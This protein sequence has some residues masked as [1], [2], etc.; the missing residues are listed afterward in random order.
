MGKTSVL[1]S[2]LSSGESAEK[3]GRYKNTEKVKCVEKSK[4][5]G[6]EKEKMDNKFRRETFD[7]TRETGGRTR[8]NIVVLGMFLAAIMLTAFFVMAAPTAVATPILDGYN[9]SDWDAVDLLATDAQDVAGN[10]SSGYDISEMWAHYDATNDTM[11]FRLDVY[12][13]PGDTDGDLNDTTSGG[14]CSDEAGIGPHETYEIWID[15]ENNG[16]WDYHITYENNAVECGENAS[17][18]ADA[19]A[20]H[21]NSSCS[22]NDHYCIVEFKILN[23]SVYGLDCYDH[24]IPYSIRGFAGTTL[25]YR[26]E[27]YTQV[28][29]VMPEA[30]FTATTECF[31][32]DTQFNDTSTPGSA[33]I[34]NWSWDFDEDGSPDS[35]D[36]NTTWH[37]PAPGTYNVTLTVTDENGCTDNITKSVTVYANPI[38]NFTVDNVCFCTN[39]TFTDTSTDPDGYIVSRY[40]EFGDGNT[41]TEQNPEW[42]YAEPGTYVVNLT[43]TDNQGCTNTTSKTV[44]VW[45][46][47]IAN[48]TA[49]PV[50]NGSTTYFTDTSINGSGTINNWTWDFGDGSPLNHTQ[51]P[52]HMYGAAGNYTVTLTVKDTNGCINTTSK[53]VTVWENPKAD[54]TFNNACFCTN[55]TF[56]D[57][58][59]EGDAPLENWTWELGDGTVKHT[60]N[61]SWHYASP[62]NYTVNLTVRDANGCENTTSKLVRVYAN[63][64]ANFTAPPVCNGSTTYFTDTSISGSG[65]INNWT[66]NFGDGSS[67]NYSRHPAHTYAAPGVYSVT[68][69]VRDT[70]GCEN[71]TTKNVTVLESPIANFTVVNACYCRNVSFVSTTTNGTPPYNYSWDFDNDGNYELI[72]TAYNSPTWHYNAPGNYTARLHVEDAAGCTNETTKNVTVYENPV[73]DFTFDNVCYCTNTTFTD[74]SSGG[75]KPYTYRWDFDNDGS[76][77]LEGDYPNPTWHLKSGTNQVRL[78][79]TDAHGCSDEIT[80]DV[81]V[82]ENPVANFSFNNACFCTNVTF[83]DTSTGGSAP[84]TYLWDFGD[85]NTST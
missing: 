85:G 42:H 73:A 48:F 67:L 12:G 47:P 17:L 16:S 40:W 63:P 55:V 56:N 51:H 59:I 46:N 29:Q 37:F 26:S 64:V 19:S 62:G 21:G 66:W 49:P 22:N 4:R 44:T 68:L 84:Y 79:I 57:T 25:D 50:C 54:F 14:N 24:C 74:N 70:N 71:S 30:N 5:L 36:R 82:Y 3:R 61:V 76:Y 38:A 35:F 27:D 20:A 77:E 15:L 81:T 58:S 10:W 1:H 39:V 53:N 45:K 2:P 9:T 72:G 7:G 60:R 34:I 75:A 65:T 83:T 28:L 43:V 11:Y 18:G 23:A 13:V 32:T 80:K 41:S 6:G 33:P 78:N 8:K 52:A 31:C 69:T